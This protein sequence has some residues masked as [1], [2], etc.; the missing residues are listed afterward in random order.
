MVQ[1]IQVTS[2]KTVAQRSLLHKSP[3]HA[4]VEKPIQ[5]ISAKA[6]A[7]ESQPQTKN[8]ALTVALKTQARSAK[9]AE[10]NYNAE[11]Y[12]AVSG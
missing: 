6:V 8:S 4:H 7:Q 1:A 3:G 9:T 10:L 11:R 5:V 12:R 2:A